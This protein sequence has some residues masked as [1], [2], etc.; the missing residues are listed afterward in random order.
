[1][2]IDQREREDICKWIDTSR[3]ELSSP[4]LDLPQEG[5]MKSFPNKGN[6]IIVIIVLSV[7]PDQFWSYNG[8]E[9]WIEIRQHPNPYWV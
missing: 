3:E 7:V 5:E 1:M 8:L 2:E 6:T 9:I 4:G